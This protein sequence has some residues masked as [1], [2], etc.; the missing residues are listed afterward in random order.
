MSFP[1]AVAVFAIAAT[2]A[3]GPVAPQ[4]GL[5]Q[6]TTPNGQSVT[7]EHAERGMVVSD[8]PE[9]SRIGHQVLRHGGNAWTRRS[10][11]PSRPIEH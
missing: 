9:A 10:R 11:R 6:P 3:G 7:P 1:R 4:R 2:S 8:R 5:A